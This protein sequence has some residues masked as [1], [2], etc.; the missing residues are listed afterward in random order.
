[1]QLKLKGNHGTVLDTGIEIDNRN[2]ARSKSI[3]LEMRLK[4][5]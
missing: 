3:I 1:M 2:K 4:D 5:Q